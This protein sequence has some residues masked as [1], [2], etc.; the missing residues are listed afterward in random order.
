[1]DHKGGFLVAPLGQSELQ[2]LTNGNL[3]MA[4]WRPRDQGIYGGRGR[5]KFVV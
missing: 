1:M 4:S 5:K 2:V 3:L